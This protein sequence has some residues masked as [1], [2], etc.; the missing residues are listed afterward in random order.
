MIKLLR[1]PHKPKS[2]FSPI[3]CPDQHEEPTGLFMNE[4][5]AKILHMILFGE[6]SLDNATLK[7]TS[8][9]LGH[10]WNVREI[11]SAC[12][13]FAAIMV[14]VLFANDSQWTEIGRQ[15]EINYLQNFWEFRKIINTQISCDSNW[16]QSLRGFYNER[17]FSRITTSSGL[18]I[19]AAGPTTSS[20]SAPPS[21]PPSQSAASSSTVGTT[22][23]SFSSAASSSSTTIIHRDDSVEVTTD[24]GTP[25]S[26]PPPTP[27]VVDLDV[28]AHPLSSDGTEVGTTV[29]L[30]PRKEVQ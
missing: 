1:F 14:Q 11:N 9:T 29:P 6:S 17:V 19:S 26:T 24:P 27:T 3:F 22:P 15:S 10:P 12:I 18:S 4:Y 7:A 13:A 8:G 16:A 30:R 5:M 21:Q 20:T 23:Q 2:A 25:S 28:P